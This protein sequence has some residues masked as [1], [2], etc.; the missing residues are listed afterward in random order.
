MWITAIIVGLLDADTTQL[1]VPGYRQPQRSWQSE[2]HF[3]RLDL[4][5]YLFKLA[6]PLVTLKGG[7]PQISY[8]ELLSISPPFLFLSYSYPHICHASL[9]SA[10]KSDPKKPE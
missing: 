3:L 2:L 6:V 10:R 9:T 4:A 1:R 7:G 5:S 8:P